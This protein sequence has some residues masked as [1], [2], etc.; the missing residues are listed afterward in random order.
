[1]TC[2]GGEGHAT[3]LHFGENLAR[4]QVLPVVFKRGESR[5]DTDLR[6]IG[7][8]VRGVESFSSVER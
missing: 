4:A 7:K 6:S 3:A 1:M 2:E 8:L 5:Q